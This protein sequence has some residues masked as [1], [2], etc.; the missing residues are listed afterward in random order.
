[1]QEASNNSFGTNKCNTTLH[2]TET[3]KEE[4]CNVTAIC[5]TAKPSTVPKF[6]FIKRLKH[7]LKVLPSDHQSYFKTAIY[8]YSLLQNDKYV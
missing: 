5:K 6:Y 2:K 7:L 4:C 8:G 3:S 1:M